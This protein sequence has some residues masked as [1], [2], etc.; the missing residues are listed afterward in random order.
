MLLA[1]LHCDT[2]FFY[3]PL[4]NAELEQCD[5]FELNMHMACYEAGVGIAKEDWLEP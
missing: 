4:A 3:E 5:I 1:G 2:L